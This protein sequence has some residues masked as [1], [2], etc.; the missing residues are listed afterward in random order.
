MLSGNVCEGVEA[1]MDG[2]MDEWMVVG[3]S[4]YFQVLRVKIDFVSAAKTTCN[5]NFP[6]FLCMFL[7]LF[8]I[9]AI[10]TQV[11]W[12]WPNPEPNRTG[13]WLLCATYSC[14]SF[15]YQVFHSIKVLLLFHFIVFCPAFVLVRAGS[16]AS[17][18]CLPF[19]VNQPP[20]RYTPSLQLL[21]PSV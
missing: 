19:P 9:E 13:C 10:T 11:G 3:F 1:C 16:A 5:D 20:V 2:W 4:K 12:E 6:T 8:S 21:P 14:L 7:F 17:N 18:L 15:I